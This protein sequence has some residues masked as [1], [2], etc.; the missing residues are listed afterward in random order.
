MR[1]LAVITSIIQIFF[2]L[3]EYPVVYRY[4]FTRRETFLLLLG[5]S[6]DKNGEDF[7][8]HVDLEIEK[9][10]RPECLSPHTSSQ[11]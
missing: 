3:M 5:T 10:R 11:S 8:S 4:I 2:I 1:P 9:Y 7:G 6:P